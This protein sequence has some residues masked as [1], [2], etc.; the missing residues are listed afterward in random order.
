MNL[1]FEF[2]LDAQQMMEQEDFADK[3][4]FND[5][6]AFHVCGNVKTH[7]V[8]VCGTSRTEEDVYRSF[9]NKIDHSPIK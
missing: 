4:T 5:E 7:N 8:C 2:C 9:S 3:L 6:S 1:P